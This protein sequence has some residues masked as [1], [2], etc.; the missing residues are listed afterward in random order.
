[1]ITSAI[2]GS[3]RPTQIAQIVPSGDWVLDQRIVDEIE[4]IL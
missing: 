1:L 3:R 2:V 4:A